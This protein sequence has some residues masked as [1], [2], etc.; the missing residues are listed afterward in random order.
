VNGPQA[1]FNEQA[2]HES[3]NAHLKHLKEWNAGNPIVI[4]KICN[5]LFERAL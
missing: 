4:G 1:I 2:S 3:Y 5:K